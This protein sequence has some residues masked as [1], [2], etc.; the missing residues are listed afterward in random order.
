MTLHQAIRPAVAALLGA[1]LAVSGARAQT[2]SLQEI[3][4][5]L[6]GEAPSAT[7]IYV[8]RELITMDSAKPRA[9]AVAVRDGRLS[10]LARR[11][12]SRPRPRRAPGRRSRPPSPTSW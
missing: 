2:S 1:I 3:T 11:P 6:V 7:T 5:D 10:R 12:R 4:G 8:A 9:Q